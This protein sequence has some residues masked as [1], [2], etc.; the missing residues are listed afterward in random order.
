MGKEILR[1]DTSLKM[2]VEPVKEPKIGH[3]RMLR[4]I[5]ERGGFGYPPVSS[6]KGD[7]LFK[8]SDVEIAR[9]ALADK[10]ASLIG[11]H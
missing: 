1:Y 7:Y 10:R 3:L 2:F 4:S 8:L 6:P 9:Y 11:K 5:A